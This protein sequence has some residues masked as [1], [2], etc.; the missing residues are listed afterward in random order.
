MARR[1]EHIKNRLFGLSI[2]LG[3]SV[4]FGTLYVL[5]HGARILKQHT[6]IRA[7]FRTI[8]G[9]RD[10]SP[11]QLA[12][13]DVGQ[14]SSVDFVKVQYACDSLTEDVGRY[15]EGRTN[16]CD[17]SLFCS[18]V[19][20]CA[21]LEPMKA[22]REHAQCIE[23]RD[24]REDEICITS[25]FEQ[26][27]RHVV[28][29]GPEGVCVRY[30]T[31]H[32]RVRVEMEVPTETMELIRR[33]SR[34]MVASNS[35]LG[36]QLVNITPGYGEALD[37]GLRV[38]TQ[39]SLSEDIENWRDRLDR[40]TEN[41]EVAMGAVTDVFDELNDPRWVGAVRGTAVNLDNITGKIVRREGLI[42]GLI[43][44]PAFKRD[45]GLMVRGIRNATA[46]LSGTVSRLN[47]LL[48]MVSR[49]V[50]PMLTETR[51]LSRSL[52]AL[53]VDLKSKDNH[54]LAAV[55]LDERSAEL[56]A[57]L[58]QLIAE[59]EGI[60]ASLQGISTSIDG[61]EGTVGKLIADPKVATDLGRLLDRL[62]DHDRTAALLRFILQITN[63]LDIRGSQ[64]P[65]G[66]R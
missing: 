31:H 51:D 5:Q 62:E 40:V 42:G 16:N 63:T 24:C 39:R 55:L 22:L 34:A 53:L 52:R 35:V 30:N 2:I 54:S 65:A 18:P 12:G 14:V 49:N 44:E 38:Q 33:D 64:D 43:S 60:A 28:W 10:G 25:E 26:R 15:G 11:V 48:S 41:V 57:N 56:A 6:T 66:P 19:G 8:A 45:L 13:V 37:T 27:E 32:M 1:R 4:T 20:L 47:S 58:E 50:D 3:L 36:D 46:G 17:G 29:A 61:A 7:D 59:V 21:D 9:L 23:S